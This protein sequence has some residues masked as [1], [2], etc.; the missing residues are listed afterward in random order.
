MFVGITNMVL[1]TNL[2]PTGIITLGH[3]INGLGLF[4]ISLCLLESSL[5][6]SYNKI[7]RSEEQARKLDKVTLI[8]LSIGFVSITLA[9]I[10]IA[11]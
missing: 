3:L 5:S 9:M 6:I 4:I 11:S 1:I 2:A 7:K 8:I 10:I